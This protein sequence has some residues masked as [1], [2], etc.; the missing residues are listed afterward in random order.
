MVNLGTKVASKPGQVHSTRARCVSRPGAEGAPDLDLLRVL[1]RHNAGQR[2]AHAVPHQAHSAGVHGAVQQ[3][4]L[5]GAGGG[6]PAQHAGREGRLQLVGG[7]GQPV[8]GTVVLQ[9]RTAVPQYATGQGGG[10]VYG[11]VNKEGRARSAGRACAW[12][13]T[14]WRCDMESAVSVSGVAEVKHGGGMDVHEKMSC[15]ASC[16]A[17][18]LHHTTST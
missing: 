10:L 7:S 5:R 9:A 17:S 12:Q 4:V 3:V 2:A 11:R 1:R 13:I 18:Y 16:P 6:G 14:A 15:E 8:G